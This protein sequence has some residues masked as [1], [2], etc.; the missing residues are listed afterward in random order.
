VNKPFQ[1][2]SAEE[3]KKI[4]ISTFNSSNNYST[5]KMEEEPRNEKPDL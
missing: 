5:P 1:K 4:V 3:G 2:E